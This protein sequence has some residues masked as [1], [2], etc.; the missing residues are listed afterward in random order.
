MN[1]IYIR[2][3]FALVLAAGAAS[4]DE[5]SW[6]NKLDGFKEFEDQPFANQ[7]AIEY[8]LTDADYSF[9][10]GNAANKA[11]AGE[12]NAAALSLVGKD[13][14]FSAACPASEYVPAFLAST[15]FDYFTLTDGSSVKLTYRVAVNEPEEL[16][17]A[18]SVQ[19]FTIPEAF[20]RD[21]VWGDEDYV[22]AFT[23]LMPAADYVPVALGD[24]LDPDNGLY[25][26]VSY[27][28]ADTEP[29]FGN[30]GDEPAPAGPVSIFEESFTESLGGFTTDDKVLP[31]ELSY[32]WS[33]GGSN[34]GA[35][36][37][38]FKDNVS[39]ATEGWLISPDIDLSGYSDITLAFDHVV[40]KFPDLGF[41]KANCTLWVSVAGAAWKQISIPE[42]TD[43]TSWT[44]TN[45]GDIKLDEFAGKTIRLG[46]KYVSEDGKSGTWEVKNL[47]ITGVAAAKAPARVR[48]NIPTT[49][50]NA[51]YHFD[52][53]DWTKAS[54]DFA[55][56]QDADYKTMGQSYNNLSAA[57]PYLSR[58]LDLN[59]PYAAADA[60]K[61]VYWVQYKSGA[62]SYVCSPYTC[63][64]DGK[65]APTDYVETETA[66]FVRTGGKWIYNPNVQIYLPAGKS[67]PLSSVYFQ[68]VV[69]WVFDN[70]CRPLGDTNIKSGLFYV[71]SYGN[72]EYY[73][74][75]SAYQGNVDLRPGSARA[76]YPAGYD[77]MTDDE[78]VEAEKSRFIYE[79]FPAALGIIHS[80]AKP[81]DGL[82]VLYTITFAAYNGTSTDYYDAVYEVTGP[83]QF[84]AISCTWWENG[85]GK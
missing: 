61:Y 68:T 5:N 26:I 33:W 7:Q 65:W 28:Q 79:S 66:Q 12:E 29:S 23:P 84:T 18:A 30:A 43:N 56:L 67:Q 16:A 14:H 31:E 63:G 70:I 76:Q 75:A 48:A 21:E 57:E 4:C 35:K 71:T 82:Q 41:A 32:I 15:D 85:T 50:V 45:S 44:F 42:Y 19:K 54:S 46:F 25:C 9:I 53:S 55:V 39:Y 60:V 80:D 6:N 27:N 20:Y 62:S 24:Y 49:A 81:I 40:N 52:G 51:V 73:S 3:F 11:L 72:N 1:K 8:T 47:A 13:K 64:E 37:S 36:A 22:N 74:G 17:E 83:G 38:A 59:Y 69:D 78:I 77:G 2:A 58:W 10:A 34:Y